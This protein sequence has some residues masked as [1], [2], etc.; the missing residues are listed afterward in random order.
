MKQKTDRRIQKTRLALKNAYIDLIEKYT[1]DQIT[2]V[3]ITQ[4]ADVN[5]A[6][7][8]DHF[9][10]KSDLLEEILCDVRDGLKEEI[11]TPFKEKNTIKIKT[12]TPTTV[13]IFEYIEKHKK[14]FH[15]LYISYPV[16]KQQ[17]EELFFEIFS[18]DIRME[19]QS[20]V[21]EVNYEM[22]LHYQTSATIGLIFFWIKNHFHSAA[23]M[24]D[25]LTILS[26]T[27]VI[28]LISVPH[29]PKSVE[30]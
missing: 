11:L 18:K 22:F 23:Y 15:A 7:F 24:M 13:R 29:S 30:D 25:Q 6:T 20:E 2:V 1:D 8:Y 28:N 12:L 5:R 3:M 21:G 9:S 14:A 19:L 4:Y 17:M 16:F 27:K 10:N 26:N